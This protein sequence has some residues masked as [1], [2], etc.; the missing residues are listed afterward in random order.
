MD[1]PLA[2]YLADHLAGS[3]HAVEVVK[4]L[5]VAYSGKPLG[6][7]AADLLL[8]IEAD[9]SVLQKLAERAGTGSSGMKEFTAWVSEKISRM[10]LKHGAGNELGTFEALEFLELGIHGKWALWH[11]LAT[12]APADP[13]L[14]GLDYE[15]L[16]SRAEMQHAKVDSWRLETARVALLPS[17]PANRSVA[18]ES[19]TR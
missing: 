9:Q 19:G 18:A 12:V 5:H 8:D 6:E 10:K 15:R 13:R 11:A 1:N 17:E 16:A 14:Q 3:V 4:N 2:T 7:F